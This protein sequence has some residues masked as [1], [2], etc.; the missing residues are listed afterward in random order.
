MIVYS[1][2]DKLT[3]SINHFVEE[4]DEAHPFAYY[5]RDEV[6]L[7]LTY[8]PNI[9]FYEEDG[10]FVVSNWMKEN[11]SRRYS[12]EFES[13]LLDRKTIA[14]KFS[15]LIVIFNKTF[16]V[17]KPDVSDEKML[18][19]L[20]LS[21]DELYARY[22][23]QDLSLLKY[24]SN[25]W[26][27]INYSGQFKFL[28]FVCADVSGYLVGL[29]KVMEAMESTKQ[30]PWLA[31][32]FVSVS[33][34]WRGRGISRLIKEKTF[35]V[36]SQLNVGLMATDYS[37]MGRERLKHVNYELA[38]KYKIKFKDQDM[39]RID[40]EERYLGRKL[41]TEELSELMNRLVK[42]AQDET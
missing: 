32:S 16:C 40:E 6:I 22:R 18:K 30:N 14:V 42:N 19:I 39:Q 41:T 33:E 21:P 28:F 8:N 13:V 23:Q 15:D 2:S 7:D 20:V 4:R 25:V 24:A 3:D 29:S 17:R 37:A 36:A 5:L 10:D 1:D 11:E 34:E 9:E 38:K 26:S 12:R 27:D 35:E 31:V